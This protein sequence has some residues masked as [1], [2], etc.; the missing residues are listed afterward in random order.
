MLYPVVIHQ[1]GNSAYGVTVPDLPGC[2]S[3]GD[4]LE[5]AIGNVNEAID[6]QLET[7]VEDGED[8]PQ[9]SQLEE[10]THQEEYS[11]G[12]WFMIEV[13]LTRYMGQIDRLNITLPHLLVTK[14]D[15]TVSEN[16]LFK[17]RSHFLVEAALR[18]LST[19]R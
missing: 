5:E 4:T 15:K 7:L 9:A 11:G 2:F 1:E 17:N 19:A 18:L 14:I 3:A 10:L 8:I 16:K 6:L 12:V 13:D